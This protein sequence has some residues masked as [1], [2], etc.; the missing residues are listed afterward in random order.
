MSV[1]YIPNMHGRC[2]I[3]LNLGFILASLFSTLT[4]GTYCLCNCFPAS[5]GRTRHPPPHIL[6]YTLPP[7]DPPLGT[8]NNKVQNALHDDNEENFKMRH[9]CYDRR[10]VYE[11]GHACHLYIY[12]YIY[13]PVYGTRV[14]N[15]CIQCIQ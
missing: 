14:W 15:Q 7:L 3:V 4:K 8:G 5:P 10:M 11:P 12:I 1:K 2:G 13:I 9:T 6:S